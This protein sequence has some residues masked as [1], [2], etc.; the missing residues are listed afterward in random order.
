MSATWSRSLPL[1]GSIGPHSPVGAFDS[2]EKAFET[3]FVRDEELKFRSTVRR[4]KL[5]GLWAARKMHMG[6]RDAADYA[7]AVVFADLER[8]DGRDAV[9]RILADLAQA[10]VMVPDDEFRLVTRDLAARA[11]REVRAEA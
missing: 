1:A 4:N 11:E 5:Y 10:G 8:A 6:E 3:T 7:R 9:A 2:R